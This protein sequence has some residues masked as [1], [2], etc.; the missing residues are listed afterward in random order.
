MST[1]QPFLNFTLGF[2]MK[3]HLTA[4]LYVPLFCGLLAI[5]NAYAWVQESQ[6]TEKVAAAAWSPEQLAEQAAPKV[7]AKPRMRPKYPR[8]GA[9][10][11]A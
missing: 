5:N 7:V 9:K 8:A 3:L 2:E 1:S 10:A 11:A 4:L 6:T